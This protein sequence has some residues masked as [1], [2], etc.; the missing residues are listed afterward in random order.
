MI[1]EIHE[2]LCSEYLLNVIR[3]QVM[4]LLGDEDETLENVMYID[5]ET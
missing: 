1:T 4:S 3:R 5:F 2:G